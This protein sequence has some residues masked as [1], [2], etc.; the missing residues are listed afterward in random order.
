MVCFKY[1]YRMLIL[2]SS[3]IREA[4]DSLSKATTILTRTANNFYN[5]SIFV[6]S[7]NQNNLKLNPLPDI[8]VK[9]I[10][11]RI[12]Q[13]D[14]QAFRELFE[15]FT[16]RLK[17]FFKKWT[18]N[19]AVVPEL[20]QETFLNIWVYRNNLANV[21]NPSAYV[22]KIATNVSVAWFR[23]ADLEKQLQKEI[24]A[25][26]SEI[27]PD[28][29]SIKELKQQIK[30]AVDQLPFQQQAVFRLS[31]EEGLSRSEIAI[32]LNLAEKTVRNH[33]TLA[34]SSIARHLKLNHHITLPLFFLDILLQQ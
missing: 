4:F 33:L 19:A 6:I 27:E 34:L 21:E 18:D 12:A 13:S 30:S 14:E 1:A 17:A 32:K 25:Q 9:D 2:C 8:Q 11:V 29:F 28:H 5:Y 15:T 16:P 22:Y 26:H 20:V 3:T 7:Q 10:F 31:R 24:T 23:K